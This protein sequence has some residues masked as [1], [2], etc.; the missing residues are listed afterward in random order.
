LCGIVCFSGPVGQN[1]NLDKIRLLLMLNQ[2][3]GKDSYG[4]YTP[5]SGIIKDTGKIEDCMIKKD[6]KVPDSNTFIGHV[7]ASTVGITSKDNAHPFNYGN[8]V[9]VMNGTLSN[10]W[11]LCKDY[12]LKLNDFDVD[13]QVLTAMINIDQSKAPLSKILGGCAVVY[14]DT[15]PG[16]LYAYRNKERPLYRGNLDDSMYISSLENSLKL[17]GCSDVKEFKEDNLYEITEGKITSTFAVK[18]AEEEVVVVPQR[19]SNNPYITLNFVDVKNVDLVG[20]WLTPVRTIMTANGAHFYYGSL[21]KVINSSVYN[22]WDLFVI[23][24]NGN[25]KLISKFQFKQIMYV[26]SIGDYV[27]ATDKISYNDT[28]GIKYASI[29]DLLVVT[30][31]TK[32]KIVCRNLVNNKVATIDESLCRYAME[33]EVADFKRTYLTIED[34]YPKSLEGEI[35]YDYVEP[36]KEV[37][38]TQMTCVNNNLPVV[39]DNVNEDQGLDSGEIYKIEVEGTHMSTYEDLAQFTFDQFKDLIHDLSECK[40]SDAGDRHLLNMMTLVTNY[41]NKYL[42]LLKEQEYASSK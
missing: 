5:E 33:A 10:H 14:T 21:Y 18:R 8:I 27:F 23:D 41:E 38:I 39:I 9:L 40:Q 7:R 30:H 22:I 31:K 29:G 28:K 42:K 4:Y 16:K 2:E 37:I 13:S 11:S 12:K 35:N 34:K 26:I 3:R 36:E 19:S 15:T 17:I 24:E 25:T 32:K 20:K 1:L 6:F